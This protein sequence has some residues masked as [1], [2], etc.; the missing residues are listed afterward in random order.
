MNPSNKK[1][2]SGL[3]IKIMM[4]ITAIL[5]VLSLVLNYVANYFDYILDQYIGAAK[6]TVTKAEGTEDWNTDYYGKSNTTAEDA[7][8][9]SRD[10]CLQVAEEG[11]VLL[12]NKDNTLPLTNTS[13]VSV[14]GWAFSNPVYGGTGSGSSDA[15]TSISPKQGLEDAGFEVNP[16]LQSSYDKWSK[17]TGNT[18]RPGAS[19][20]GVNASSSYWMLPE[21][22]VT[23]DMVAQAADYSDTAIV[24]IARQGGEGQDEALNMN[25]ALNG[26]T[27]P[28]MG[29]SETKHYLELTDA[30]EAT[31]SAL[32]QNDGIKNIVVVINSSNQ[33]ELAELEN[34]PKISAV[35]YAA[36]GGSTGFEAVGEILRG[37]VNPSG[38]LA[39]TMYANFKLDPTYQNVSDPNLYET[40]GPS[41]NWYGAE[42]R[43]EDSEEGGS[44]S[45]TAFM[46][47][48]EGIYLGYRY[49]ETAFDLATESAGQEAADAWYY[50]W[51]KDEPITVGSTTGSSDTG[52]VYPFGYGLSYTDFSWEVVDQKLDVA[53]TDSLSVTVKVTNNG[54]VAGKDVVELYYTAPYTEGGAEKSTVVMGAYEKTGLIQPGASENVTLTLPVEDM[55]S[56]DQNH[57]NSDGTTGCYVLDAGD[58]KLTLRTD[59]HTVKSDDCVLTYTVNDTKAYDTDANKRQSDLTAA[60]NAFTDD[61][62]ERSTNMVDFSRADWGTKA[63]EGTFPTM[64]TDEDR[65]MSD[66]LKTA[67]Q[68]KTA[69]GVS[70]T[71]GTATMT[72]T[73]SPSAEGYIHDDDVMPTT[74]AENGIQLISLRGLSYDDEAWNDFMDQLTVDEMESLICGGSFASAG[75]DRLGIPAAADNDGPAAIKWQGAAGDVNGD[76][77][78]GSSQAMPSEVVMAC[79][80]ND[81]LI[82]EVGEAIGEEGLQNGVSGWY[83]PGL[84]MHRTPFGGRNFEYFSEDPVLAGNLCAQEVSGAAS[85]GVYAYVKHFV[86]N[87]TETYRNLDAI[88]N[89]EGINKSWRFMGATDDLTCSI[90]VTEQALREIYMKPYEIVVKT[91]TTEES[92][93]ADENGTVETKTVPA[94][95]AIMSAFTYIGQTWCGANSNLLNTVLRDE[96][97]FQGTVITDAAAYPYMSQDN[98]VF[99][100]GDLL[101]AIGQNNLLDETK[102]TASG[103]IAMR[104]ATK[105]I[106]YTKVNSNAM[107]EVAPNSIIH[108]GIAPWQ[109]LCYGIIAV[110]AVLFV[111]V[112]GM[113]FYG[114]HKNKKK[115]VTVEIK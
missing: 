104:R 100:G 13:K 8:Q 18:V 75:I 41:V 19:T 52:V 70:M 59:A 101:L 14:F 69:G 34:D 57:A 77:G 110:C 27:D 51:K 102:N 87:D 43:I 113:F 76:G 92:Y 90:W 78:S 83:A 108:T 2:K 106:L 98:F 48:E 24:W 26:S 73:F 1:G 67:L 5:L 15:S 12:K 37:T 60:T 33:M 80:W 53:T 89:W 84:D 39:D 46:Q 68:G 44:Y 96:W 79:T 82:Y 36:A 61:L 3:A 64:A 88:G 47:Y 93:I 38:K 63:G 105:N 65:V 20:D 86:V 30:E 55:A 107:N 29:Y 72:G 109:Y 40:T 45:Y 66:A 32:E 114:L 95:T 35:L 50:G 42:N 94:C 91:A 111:V 115:N 112:W 6:V 99:N 62:A 25:A 54:S 17:D 31:I 81:D 22:P 9:H 71:T 58:Y 49:Y 97:G 7:A 56:Y 74:G 85:K 16:T 23:D 10:V 4:P 28:Q 21:M 11:F 103:V